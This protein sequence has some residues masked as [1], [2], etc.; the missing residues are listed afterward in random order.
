MPIRT[1]TVSRQLQKNGIRLHLAMVS[2]ARSGTG[3]AGQ[4]S[5]PCRR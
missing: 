3:T 5:E 2:H 4:P 1:A